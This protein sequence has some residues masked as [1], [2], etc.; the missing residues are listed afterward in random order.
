MLDS[1]G[2]KRKRFQDLFDEMEDKAKEAWGENINTS[3][4]SPLGIILRLFA[5]FLAS[6]WSLAESVYNSGYKN[7]ADGANLDRLGPFI[8]T[9]RILEQWAIGKVLIRGTPGHSEAAGFQVATESGVYFEALENFTIDEDG[10]VLVDVEALESGAGGNV[11]AETITIIV[12]PNPDITS[13]I[14]PERTQGGREKETDAEFR[15][16]WDE[17]VAGGGAASL[18]AIEAVLLKLE[19]VRAAKVIQNV[20]SLP[21]D[22]G[23]P[24]KSFQA[25]VLGGQD[26]AIGEA[27][28]EKGAAGIEPYGDIVVSVNDMG[29]YP[30]EVA[31]SR[32]VEVDLQIRIEL[33]SNA[34]YPVNGDE[35]IR[36]ALVRYIGGEDQGSYYNG[37]NMGSPVIY[38]KL[39]STVYSV[40]GIDDLTIEIGPAGAMGTGNVSVQPYQVPQISTESIEVIHV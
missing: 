9:T 40:S 35:L 36:S 33:R 21:D 31:F 1:T 34:S 2:F 11:A 22:A 23:R 10:T 5:W 24:P 13:V 38:T 4:R 39:I 25:Y 32:A 17:T 19:G 27:I 15:D 16:R 28:F 30:H 29:G 14:N 18:P 3:A 6:V 12:N 26:Q 37:L 20:S 7:T 8:G